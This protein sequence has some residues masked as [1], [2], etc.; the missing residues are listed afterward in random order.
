M[1]DLLKRLEEFVG[2]VDSRE[3]IVYSVT[4]ADMTLRLVGGRAR[5]KRR[6]Q[7][8]P[9]LLFHAAAVLGGH[10]AQALLEGL[11]EVADDKLGHDIDDITDTPPVNSSTWT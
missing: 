8:Y 7:D 4:E 1:P 3:E 2:S 6:V 10:A 9:H 11:V 5:R